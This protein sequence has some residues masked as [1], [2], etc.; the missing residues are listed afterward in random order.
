MLVPYMVYLAILF[1][2]Q[3]SKSASTRR[4]TMLRRGVVATRDHS[5]IAWSGM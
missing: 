3:P 1:T 5:W 4:G 2:L